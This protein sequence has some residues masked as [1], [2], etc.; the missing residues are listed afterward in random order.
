MTT[1]TRGE[2]VRLFLPREHERPEVLDN[3]HTQH[4][5]IEHYTSLAQG[6]VS[7]A[8]W[9]TVISVMLIVPDADQQRRGGWPRCGAWRKTKGGEEKGR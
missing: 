4:T 7:H 2:C 3:G 9:L 8:L 5:L 1:S 6:I